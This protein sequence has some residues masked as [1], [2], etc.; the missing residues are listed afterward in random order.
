MSLISLMESEKANVERKDIGLFSYGSGCGAEFML[1]HVKSPIDRIIKNLKFN[2][3]L[4]RRKKISFEQ[5]TQIYSKSAEEIF[6]YL[7]EAKTFKDQFTKFVFTGFE[8][9]KRMYI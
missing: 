7:E 3:Q 1:C 2:E 4:K 9:H 6:Y 8:G 5:Y